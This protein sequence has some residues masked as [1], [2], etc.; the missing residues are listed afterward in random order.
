MG[1]IDSNK[2]QIQN[3]K[4]CA[5]QEPDSSTSHHIS[6]FIC[7]HLSS[8]QCLPLV[9]VILFLV[10]RLHLVGDLLV[11]TRCHPGGT[12]VSVLNL[13]LPFFVSVVDH[14]D[15]SALYESSHDQDEGGRQPD[16]HS[17]QQE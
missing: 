11:T 16:I 6:I 13:F 17:L 14:G 9:L 1:P 2:Y 8:L 10:C 5:R 12:R 15:G 3:R 4:Q 7:G